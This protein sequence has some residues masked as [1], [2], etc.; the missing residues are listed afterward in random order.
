V[1]DVVPFDEDAESQ[2]VGLLQV[3]AAYVLAVICFVAVAV[4]VVHQTLGDVRQ[5]CRTKRQCR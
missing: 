2:F 4:C 5:I 3:E 1:I